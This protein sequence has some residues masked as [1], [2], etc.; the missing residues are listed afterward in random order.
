MHNRRHVKNIIH[1]EIMKN[2]TNQEKSLWVVLTASIV[3]YGLY[4]LNVLP[5]VDGNMGT[6]HIWQ[7]AK[8][9]GAFVVIVIIGEVYLALKNKQEPVDERARLIGLKADSV[10]TYILYSGILLA[11]VVALWKPGNFWFIHTIN[12]VAVLTEIINQIQQLRAFRK[13][14]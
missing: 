7:Y 5:P 9:M 13:G 10:S 1:R 6:A 11:I 12:F 3:I 8:Y 2:M 14:F 4:Y